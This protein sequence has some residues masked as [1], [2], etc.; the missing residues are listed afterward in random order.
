MKSV[1]Y[2]LSLLLILISVQFAFAQN[3]MIS[4]NGSP[5]EPSIMMDPNNP[6]ILVAGSN[7]F[8]YYTSNDGGLTWSS[9]KLNSSYGVWGDP[10][11]DIDTNG[12]FYFFHLSNTPGGSW[13]DRIV[14]QKSIDNGNTWS[15]GTYTGLDGNKV[16]DKQWS[17]IDRNNNNIY[18]TWTEFDEYGSENILDSSRILF[19]KSLDEGET[20]SDAKQINLNSGNCID[21]DSTV[22][23]ATPTIGP[24]GELYVSWA[25]PNGLVFNR[26]TDEGETWLIEEIFVDSMP[27][28]WA[29]YIPG[30]QRANG[31]P[32]TKCDLSGGVNHGTIYIN[33]SDQ[34]N[35]SNDTDIWLIKSTDGGDT[36]SNRIRVNDDNSKKH[37][38]LTWMDVDQTNGNLFFVF[39]DRRNYDDTQTDVYMAT[40]TDGGATFSNTRISESPFVPFESVFFGDYTNVVAHNNVVRPIWTRFDGGRLSI[41]TN[42]T[43]ITDLISSVETEDN[44]SSNA[45]IYP[46]PTESK[47]Y[48]SFKLHQNS[49]IRLELLDEKGKLVKVVINNE[50]ME[51]GGHIIPIDMNELNLTSGLYFY[52]LSING[53]RETLKTILLK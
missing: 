43:P 1:K 36:W 26:S 50:V 24:N 11:I 13:I 4:N 14:C 49:T 40:S 8:F 45:L 2:I 42:V 30:L 10:V 18:L 7:L 33:W 29:Y 22:E 31:L 39:Y 3:V 27:G 35:G 46:N 12:N 47:S 28:G 25:G 17:A 32:V 9:N 20:W 34:L 38:F 48:I 5:N 16:Q 53:T 37:Q 41:W 6:N 51:Y 15:D 44:I 52:T 23:G 21:G 19:S